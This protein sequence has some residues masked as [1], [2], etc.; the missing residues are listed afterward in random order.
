[1]PEFRKNGTRERMRA[2]LGLEGP[3]IVLL[4]IG[5]SARTKGF[6]RTVSALPE[7]PRA[8]LLV[9]GIALESREGTALLDQ[10]RGLGV[11][12]RIRLLGPRA[13]VPELMAAADVFVHPA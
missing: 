11:A 9:C 10:A 13:D 3:S 6:D 1:H 5:T 8:M 4:S 12:G 7:F 2:E